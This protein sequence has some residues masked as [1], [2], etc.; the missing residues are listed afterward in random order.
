LAARPQ[1]KTQLFKPKKVIRLFCT[2]CR[3]LKMNVLEVFFEEAIL[4][5]S[6]SGLNPDKAFVSNAFVKYFV[7]QILS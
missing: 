4:S 6:M 5:F 1:K 7:T 3:Q 2:T